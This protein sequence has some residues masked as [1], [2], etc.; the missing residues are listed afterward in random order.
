MPKYQLGHGTLTID[1]L[2]DIT[3]N[4]ATVFLAEKGRDKVRKA[5]ELVEKWVNENRAVYGVTTGFG[6]L[7]D[8]SIPIKDA[9]RLQ[10]KPVDEPRGRGR[11]TI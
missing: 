10:V 2:V 11:K 4:H 1:N 3:R 6:A 8:V 7:S 9:R 5:R